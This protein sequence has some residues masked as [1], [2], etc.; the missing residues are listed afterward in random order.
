LTA[1]DAGRYSPRVLRPSTVL[2]L[3]LLALAGCG[4]VDLGDNFVPPDLV[5]DEDFF[6]CRIQP[7]VIGPQTC[8]SGA[9]GDGGACHSNRSALRLDPVAE[10]VPA[11]ACDGDVLLGTPPP[12]YERNLEALRFT[13]QSDPLSSPLYRRPL[14]LDSHPRMIF[15]ESSPEADL[16]VQWILTGGS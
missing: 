2:A 3:V 14:A 9:A 4:T 8:A 5:L 12:E 13:V 10:T 15:D 11:P 1:L 6:Y 16:I 7:E